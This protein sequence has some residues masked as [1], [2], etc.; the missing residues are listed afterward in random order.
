MVALGG[1]VSD[2]TD[3]SHFQGTLPDRMTTLLTPFR[4]LEEYSMYVW[5]PPPPRLSSALLAYLSLS[6]RRTVLRSLEWGRGS[7]RDSWSGEI[8]RAAQRYRKRQTIGLFC[9]LSSPERDSQG[10]CHRWPSWEA[11]PQKGRFS[12]ALL[13]SGTAGE[14]LRA[15]GPP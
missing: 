15:E 11:V 5:D 2:V 9:P 3:K 13:I 12:E 14:P 10:G 4:S 8:H 6:P 1:P 7:W